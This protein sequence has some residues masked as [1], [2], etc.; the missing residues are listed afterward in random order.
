ME[1]IESEAALEA[2]ARAYPGGEEIEE[3]G[4]LRVTCPAHRAPRGPVP[5]TASKRFIGQ[6]PELLAKY[7]DPARAP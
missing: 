3:D 7:G 4:W 1:A 2:G 6:H 5:S